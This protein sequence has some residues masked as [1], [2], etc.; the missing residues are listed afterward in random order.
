MNMISDENDSQMIPGDEC[1]SSFLTFVLQL[2]KNLGQILN[3]E[4]DQNADRIRTAAL[5]AI[6]LPSDHNGDL[7]RML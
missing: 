2:T 6:T 3:Q 4:I 5:E 7:P 1:G